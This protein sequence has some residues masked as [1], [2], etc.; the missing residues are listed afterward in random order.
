MNYAVIELRKLAKEEGL[1]FYT[2]VADEIERL[3]KVLK[4]TAEEC[5]AGGFVRGLAQRR[6]IT[7]ENEERKMLAIAGKCIGR[8]MNQQEAKP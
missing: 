1:A 2:N 7:M 6:G 8:I 5:L 3:E 4:L